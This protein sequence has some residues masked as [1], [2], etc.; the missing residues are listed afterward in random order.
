[1]SLIRRMTNQKNTQDHVPVPGEEERP[2]PPGTDVQEVGQEDD[3]IQ[4]PEADDDLRALEEGAPTRETEVAVP[5]LNPEIKSAKK[6]R[7]NDP[8]PHPRATVQAGDP[9]VQA[10]KGGAGRVA[11]HLD[12]LKKLDRLRGKHLAPH[13]PEDIKRKRRRIKTGKRTEMKGRDLPVKRRKAKTK[14]R[15][16]SEDQKVKKT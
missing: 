13:H 8:R 15:N 12:P 14:R 4:S 10:G 1:M 9:A 11:L 3:L 6:K 2:H 7:K 5:D 16:E